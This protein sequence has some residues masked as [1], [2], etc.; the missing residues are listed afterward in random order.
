MPAEPDNFSAD[1]SQNCQMSTKKNLRPLSI[2]IRKPKSSPLY[3]IIHYIRSFVCDIY[4]PD[5]TGTCFCHDID[6]R[7]SM[8][9]ITHILLTATFKQ[10]KIVRI[11]QAYKNIQM[12]FPVGKS[13]LSLKGITP[14]MTLDLVRWWQPKHKPNI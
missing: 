7:R 11:F 13:R 4:I 9:T 12:S 1:Y 6:H 14:F 5:E 3:Q 2:Q 10:G 8:D